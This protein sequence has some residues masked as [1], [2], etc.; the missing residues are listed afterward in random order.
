M[1]SS[2]VNNF[3]KT[4][5]KLLNLN[6]Y[7]K[8]NVNLISTLN[9]KMTP[10]S[11]TP[12]LNSINNTNTK[13]SFFGNTSLSTN[14]LNNQNNKK[15]EDS[16]IFLTADKVTKKLLVTKIN[17]M[18]VNMIL[19]CIILI[20]LLIYYIIKIIITMNFIK[21]ITTIFNDYGILANRFGM[22]QDY[23][24]SFSLLLINKNLVNISYF[25]DMLEKVQQQ[26]ILINE[27]KT[28]RLSNYPSSFKTI[29]ILNSKQNIINS[30][31][32]TLENTLCKDSI[33]CHNILQN[34]N[35]TMAKNG[36]NLAVSSITQGIDRLVN[37]YKKINKNDLKDIT[38]VKKYFINIQFYQISLNLNFVLSTTI[39][40]VDAVFL[41]DAI[42]LAGSHKNTVIIS[43]LV[44]IF[45]LSGSFLFVIFV[46]D[47][48]FK[49]KDFIQESIYR[50]NK[51]FSYIK[52]VNKG[53]T[54]KTTTTFN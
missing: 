15:E 46:T 2:I 10:G 23:F 4:N 13:N 31:G 26:N 54:F 12:S 32:E 22:A 36:V 30:D 14:S 49:M 21:S 43:N 8:N 20:T 45:Y 38:N 50:L 52:E 16:N 51:V 47:K 41:D 34:E 53:Y 39:D 17:F 37:D 1:S 28:E 19:D 11:N 35:L 25:D 24:N 40:R 27:M 9:K 3:S 7:N 33:P 29:K 44:I 18:K 42:K 5:D 48:T 6:N